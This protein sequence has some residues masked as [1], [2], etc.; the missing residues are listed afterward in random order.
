MADDETAPTAPGLPEDSKLTT[1]KQRWAREGRFLTGRVTRPDSDRLP[2]GQ[3]L[4]RD[5]PVL[6]L[7]LQPAISRVQWRL[8]VTGLVEHP[9]SWSW[10]EFLDQ[11]QTKLVT[12]MHCVTTWS[13]YDNGWEGMLVRDLLDIVMPKPEASHVMMH[14]Y[15]GYTTNVALEDFG[16]EDALLVHSW[17]GAPLAREHGGPVRVLIPH[18]YLWKSAKWVRQIEFM[19]ADKRGFWE[20]RGYHNHADPWTEERYSDD[21]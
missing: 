11:K 5:W 19:A 15:D 17:E 4:V 7:G 2:P 13:R 3:H 14:S 1:T 10:Q 12:D 21:E 6:D 9:V 8:D 20:E 18:L 16:A